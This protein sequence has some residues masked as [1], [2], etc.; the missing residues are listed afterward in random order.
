MP[1]ALLAQADG[2]T[3]AILNHNKPTAYLVSAKTYEMMLETIE[4]IER[5]DLAKSRL[6][7]KNK[8][9]KI[10]LKDL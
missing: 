3:V 2:E 1:S 4:N 7:D 9:V 8:A 5:L 10:D 6:K